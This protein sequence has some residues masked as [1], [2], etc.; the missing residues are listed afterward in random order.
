MPL[1]ESPESVKLCDRV[2][3]RDA[4][5]ADAPFSRTAFE[6]SA[7]EICAFE[8][9]GTLWL[10][11]ATALVNMWKSL[12]SAMAVKGIKTS[13]SFPMEEVRV[14]VEEDGHESA[15]LQAVLTRLKPLGEDNMADCK[16]FL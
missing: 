5:L 6:Q 14:F 2:L 15:L 3:S 12:M 9:K 16:F 10:P 8:C 11:T 1:Y 13:A 7:V 4:L